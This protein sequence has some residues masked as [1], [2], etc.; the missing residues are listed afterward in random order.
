MVLAAPHDDL[1]FPVDTVD[2]LL[3]G[4]AGL[5]DAAPAGLRRAAAPFREA[6]VTVHPRRAVAPP[7]QALPCCRH[8]E[9]AAA[10]ARDSR[11]AEVA[12]CAAILAGEAFWT[13]NPN[14]QR[15]PPGPGFLD[16]YG[17]FVVAGPADG[18]PAFVE[19]SALALGLLLLGPGTVYP[20]HAH[21]AEELYIPLAGD[22][23]WRMGD[24]PW[25]VE[26]AGSLIH[27]PSGVAHATRAGAAPLLAVYL[28]RGALATHARLAPG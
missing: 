10:A 1:L 5:I 12:A 9:Q 22:A 16:N 24:G 21:P 6:L 13:Q 25:R 27:H 19:V 14:Y 18:P 26:P 17:Y 15:R 23:E 3:R 28:W 8:L 4:I 20:A 11:A 7:L 2:G